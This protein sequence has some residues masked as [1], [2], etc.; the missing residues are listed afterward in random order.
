MWQ[1]C[2]TGTDWSML[3]AGVNIKFEG[4]KFDV[5]LVV[6]GT[7]S[8]RG[9]AYG[10]QESVNGCG[11]ERETTGLVMLPARSL[12]GSGSEEDMEQRHSWE[13]GAMMVGCGDERQSGVREGGIGVN[14]NQCL[15]CKGSCGC[16]WGF[17]WGLW[18][19]I[20]IEVAGGGKEHSMAVEERVGVPWKQ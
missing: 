20:S 15:L 4:L 16:R 3:E 19:E 12:S 7:E 1:G 8:L 14:I 18:Q 11:S 10:C 13:A 2:S 17:Q 5:E 9:N 6:G